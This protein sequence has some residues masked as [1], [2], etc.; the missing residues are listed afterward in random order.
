MS[1]LEIKRVAEEQVKVLSTPFEVDDAMLQLAQKYGLPEE[2]LRSIV[3]KSNVLLKRQLRTRYSKQVLHQIIQQAVKAEQNQL[4]QVG[5]AM[6]TANDL[7]VPQAVSLLVDNSDPDALTRLLENLTDALPE[8][9][10]LL[11]LVAETQE[12]GTEEEGDEGK[13]IPEKAKLIQEYGDLRQKLQTVSAELQYKQDKLAYL[14][15]LNEALRFVHEPADGDV[16]G[17]ASRLT[18][19]GQKL[20]FLSQK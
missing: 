15:Q 1:Y 10:H 4:L 19:L 9:R 20:Q 18:V 14:Q 6:A 11:A 5:D 13:E 3:F 17:Q 12:E 7:V 8:P 2:E 16:Q